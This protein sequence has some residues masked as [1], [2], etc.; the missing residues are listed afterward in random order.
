ME[1]KFVITGGCGFIGSHLV[2]H[3]IKEN[4]KV[5]VLDNLSTGRLENIKNFKDKL[6]FYK[7]DIKD[8]KKIEKYFKN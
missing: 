2:D 6:N 7:V 3:L 8:K 4:H 5:I 1:K